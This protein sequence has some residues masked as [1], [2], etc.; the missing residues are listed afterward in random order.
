[1]LDKNK[2]THFM[3]K[4]NFKFLKV[5]KIYCL[6]AFL[7]IFS[8][9]A[10]NIYSQTKSVS[11]KMS[12]STLKNVF[13]EIEKNTDYLF[14]IMDDS[15]RDMSKKVSV[16]INDKT[17]KETL[18]Y[19][20]KDTDLAYAIVNRQITIH[21]KKSSSDEI[22]LAA[23]DTN[24]KKITQQNK[25]SITGT[26]TDVNGQSIIG[27][28]IIDL[29]MILPVCSFLS[30]DGLTVNQGAVSVDIPVAIL[31]VA[32]T[33]FPTIMAGKFSRW[34]GVTIFGIYAG[35]IVTMVV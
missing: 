20:L 24:D 10:E 11:L 18:D 2:L 9:A 6:L 3:L 28:N 25:R 21:S 5:M 7:C 31:L 27:A 33:V 16:D 26:I 15:G 29:T 22:H 34:Q 32:I 13:N 17:I 8:V 4:K 12:N 35:Y 14:L 19:L 1:M 23:I 30:G